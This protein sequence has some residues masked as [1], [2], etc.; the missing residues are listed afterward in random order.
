MAYNPGDTFFPK[1]LVVTYR[2]L[3]AV[4]YVTGSLVDRDY[5]HC[6]RPLTH[7]FVVSAISFHLWDCGLY[8]VKLLRNTWCRNL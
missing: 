8:L 2:H 6:S 1:Q 7:L 3:F 4:R 5:A